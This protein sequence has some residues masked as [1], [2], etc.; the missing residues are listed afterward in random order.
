MSIIRRFRKPEN[1]ENIEYKTGKIRDLE[2]REFKYYEVNRSDNSVKGELSLN[3]DNK[4]KTI[5]T[6]DDYIEWN[7]Q[8]LVIL[9]DGYLYVIRTFYDELDPDDNNFF[10]IKARKRTYLTLVRDN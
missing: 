5:C 3:I 4:V 9:D 7:T 8:Y 2:Y 1:N 10:N 6:S